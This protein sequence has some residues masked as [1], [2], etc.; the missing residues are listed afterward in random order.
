MSQEHAYE[1]SVQ[2]QMSD[3][4]PLSIS[5]QSQHSKLQYLQQSVP[6]YDTEN[7]VFLWICLSETELS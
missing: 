2:Q 1:N 3:S 4:L 5:R 7:F 6:W